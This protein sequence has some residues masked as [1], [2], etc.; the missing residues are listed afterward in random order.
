MTEAEQ[1]TYE[2]EQSGHADNSSEAFRDWDNASN[3]NATVGASCASCHSTAGFY[4][5]LLTDNRTIKNPPL[6]ITNVGITCEACHSDRAAAATSVKFEASGQTVNYPGTASVICGQCHQ[7]RTWGGSVDTQIKKAYPAGDNASTVDKISSKIGI[8][9]PHYAAAFAATKAS[10][11]HIAYN[12]GDTSWDVDSTHPGGTDCM[13]CHNQHSTEINVGANGANCTPCHDFANKDD[14]LTFP[15]NE[16]ISVKATQLYSII[17]QYAADNT[18]LDAAGKTKARACIVYDNAAYPYWFYDTNCDGV[19]DGGQYKSFTPRLAKACFNLMVYKK[20]PGIFAHNSDYA[21]AFLNASINNLKEYKDYP[22]T[23]AEEAT[24]EWEQSGHADYDSMAFRDWDNASNP[25]AK[26]PAGCASCHSTSGFNQFLINGNRTVANPPLAVNNYGI[27]CYACHSPQAAA[28]TSVKFEAS[29]QT[30]ANPGQSSV[31][32][33]QCHQ[34]RTW[35][36][37]VET[38]IKKAYPA[39]DNATTR[40][41]ISSKIGGT[42]PHYRAAFAALKASKSRIGY[43]YGDLTIDVDSTHPGGTDCMVCHNQHST[44]VKTGSSC[45][46]CHPDFTSIAAIRAYNSGYNQVQS[47]EDSLLTQIQLYAAADNIQDA[48][49]NY[50]AKACIVYDDLAYPYWFKDDGTNGDTT[51]CDGSQDNATSSNSFK[52]FTPRLARACY[53]YLVSLKDPGGYAHNKNYIKNLLI[54]SINDLN[55]YLY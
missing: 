23:D 40:D 29:G 13:V 35:Q 28:M 14:V 33:G 12:Y 49:G 50:K 6:A 17:K 34:G 19:A 48:A 10:K 31:I 2:W 15:S 22:V 11:S 37:S 16:E 42:N 7:G 41:K 8:T 46:P 44:E 27:T 3:P 1:A 55:S 39:G 26:V 45:Q 51:A 53:N 24:Y 20:D 18:T 43:D 21:M 47:L 5:F 38:Q 36:A 4:E 32:C 30:V 9:N 54:K 52:S 25:L